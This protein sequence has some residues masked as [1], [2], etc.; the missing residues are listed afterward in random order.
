MFGGGGIG[1]RRD[2][3]GLRARPAGKAPSGRNQKRRCLMTPLPRSFYEPAAD[4]VAPRLLGHL[5]LRK[6]P[7]GLAG[8]PI[9]EVEAYLFEDPASHSFTGETARNRSM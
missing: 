8:G 5:L 7:Q 9:V 1:G 3:F 2:H 6:T 4:K